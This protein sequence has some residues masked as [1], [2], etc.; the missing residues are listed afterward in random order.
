LSSK[1]LVAF[2]YLLTTSLY[3]FL[4]Y[5]LYVVQKID[6]VF[7][8]GVITLLLT[9]SAYL[10]AQLATEPLLRYI[11]HLRSISSQTLHEL[12]LPI[13]TI[14]TNLSLLEKN[15]SS[16]KEKKRL[17]RIKQATTMLQQRYN[18][19]DYLIKKQT[20]KEIKENFSIK[21]LLEERIS[22]LQSLYPSHTIILQTE[23]TTLHTD[24]IGLS[25]VIDNLIDNSVKYSP[26][27]S[28]IQILFQNNTLQVIDTG[29]GIDEVQLIRIFDSYYQEDTNAKGFG[30]GLFMVKQFCD[31]NNIELQ[32]RSKVNQGTT[33]ELRFKG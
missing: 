1:F 3:L 27:H 24:K 33:V 26:K 13:A 30:I 2:F 28:K 15:I 23:D 7:V 25:K 17:N 9:L 21:E 19:L 4:F 8:V 18:E 10:I 31:N 6:L 16:E 5:F 20:T 12:N 11:N 14:R 32:I 22:F 29:K